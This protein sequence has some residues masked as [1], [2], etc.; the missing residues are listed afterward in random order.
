MNKSRQYAV[1]NKKQYHPKNKQS[2]K[3][4]HHPQK[5]GSEINQLFKGN[6]VNNM[7]FGNR[8][9]DLSGYVERTLVVKD[10]QGNVQVAKEKQFFNSSK[11][12]MRVRIKDDDRE[13]S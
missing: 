13:P 9:H 12:S 5:R 6:I 11:N 7:R 4:Y 2:N 1:A 3:R 10:R 8:D